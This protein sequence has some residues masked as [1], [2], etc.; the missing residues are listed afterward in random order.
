MQ[1]ILLK[2]IFYLLLNEIVFYDGAAARTYLKTKD[3]FTNN[4]INFI[5]HSPYS[6]DFN[7]NER[8]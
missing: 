8:V 4:K 2:L 3:F 7:P 5:L 1:M 6:S